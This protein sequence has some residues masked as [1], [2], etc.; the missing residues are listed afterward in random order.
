MLT[1]TDAVT[2]AK[3]WTEVWDSSG[4]IEGRMGLTWQR[5]D[6]PGWELLRGTP[7]S[8]RRRGGEVGEGYL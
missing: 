3:H 6:M 7:P 4:R 5:L 2:T 1:E 8:Q